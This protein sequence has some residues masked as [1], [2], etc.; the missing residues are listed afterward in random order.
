[1]CTFCKNRE[2]LEEKGDMAKVMRRHCVMEGLKSRQEPRSIVYLARRFARG[3]R[4]SYL[5]DTEKDETLFVRPQGDIIL[6]LI[7][8]AENMN[9]HAVH[10]AGIRGA[11]Y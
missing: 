9:H 6:F 7:C 10:F 5:K 2:E 8:H 11:W 1:M 3:A 4:K